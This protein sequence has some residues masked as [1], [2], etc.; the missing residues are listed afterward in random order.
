LS[1]KILEIFCPEQCK[2]LKNHCCFGPVSKAMKLIFD[3]ENFGKFF[4]VQNSA[5]SLKFT[6]K[7]V[8]TGFKANKAD[9]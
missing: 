4:F 9:F 3:Q 2:Q 6:F 1:K 8:L 7:T 5:N